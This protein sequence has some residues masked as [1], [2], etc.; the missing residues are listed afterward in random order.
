MSGGRRVAVK[1]H[2]LVLVEDQTED[3]ADGPRVSAWRAAGW[4]GW[5]K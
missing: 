4:C 3:A 2:N 5:T 1:L